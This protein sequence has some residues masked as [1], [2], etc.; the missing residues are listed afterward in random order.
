MTGEDGVLRGEAAI[1]CPLKFCTKSQ[2]AQILALGLARYITLR[3]ESF[4][5][6][7]IESCVP[8]LDVCCARVWSRRV[9]GCEGGRERRGLAVCGDTD[10]ASCR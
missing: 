5:I 7:S 4:V 6:Q 3:C 10:G 9:R 1:E 2:L 8:C